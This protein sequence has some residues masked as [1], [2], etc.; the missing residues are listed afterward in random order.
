VS[1]IAEGGFS[2]ALI[3]FGIGREP[4]WEKTETTI[5]RVRVRSYREVDGP[6]RVAVPSDN[7]LVFST[8][9]IEECLS[10]L[11][12]PRGI[13]L[14]P[15]I[16][17]RFEESAAAAYLP[18]ENPGVLPGA[19]MESFGLPAI[20]KT[21]LFTAERRADSRFAFGGTLELAE[22]RDGRA[23]AVLLRLLLSA[24]LAAMGRTFPEIRETLRVEG[25]ENVIDLSGFVLSEDETAEIIR[26]YLKNFGSGKKQ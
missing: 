11:Y 13:V 10:R 14:P 24:R 7:L 9:D 21:L 22:G 26:G 12:E 6:G 3:E 8:G 18:G 15:G 16:L 1:L 2:G 5:G 19:V 25:R 20:W 4:G 23:P 17:S